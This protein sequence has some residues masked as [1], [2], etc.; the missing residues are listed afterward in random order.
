MDYYEICTRKANELRNEIVE[1]IRIVL[2]GKGY[3]STHDTVRVEGNKIELLPDRVLINDW[4]TDHLE[5]KDLLDALH[6][7]Y[8]AFPKQ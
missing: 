4:H 8:H 6:A 7:A 3:N 2:E 5:I 1:D